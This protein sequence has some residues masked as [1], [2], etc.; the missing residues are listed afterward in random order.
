MFRL[1]DSNPTQNL[2]AGVLCT[3]T[4]QPLV[5]TAF[6]MV[7]ILE[8]FLYV[9]CKMLRVYSLFI[10]STRIFFKDN[11]SKILGVVKAYIRYSKHRTMIP[12]VII[13]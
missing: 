9:I 11:P 6:G 7:E 5:M 1:F 13:M 4:F 8:T 10:M 2:R 3:R 12:F